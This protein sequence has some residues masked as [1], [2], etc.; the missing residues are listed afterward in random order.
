MLH[1]NIH[2]DSDQ[3]FGPF[4]APFVTTA[5]AQYPVYSTLLHGDRPQ[6]LIKGKVV[7]EENVASAHILIWPPSKVAP[8][9]TV[10]LGAM[11]MIKPV[12]DPR[13]LQTRCRMIASPARADIVTGPVDKE[14]DF[15]IAEVR[16]GFRKPGKPEDLTEM[17]VKFENIVFPRPGRFEVRI[18][19]NI[20]AFLDGEEDDDSPLQRWPPPDLWPVWPTEPFH[21]YKEAGFCAGVL[22][23]GQ[24]TEV[25]EQHRGQ[26]FNHQ[27]E[28]KKKLSKIPENC[29]Q[30]RRLWVRPNNQ[31]S[32]PKYISDIQDEFLE[33][34]NSNYGEWAE[35][36]A[37]GSWPR[38]DD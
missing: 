27:L 26:Y 13:W 9:E 24:I 6:P 10:E 35:Y 4:K 22:V 29:K 8:N 12:P 30:G 18:E 33:K 23:L 21:L 38:F 17:V 15:V 2:Y 32:Q 28:R 14:R 16:H 20:C 37:E 31:T 1:E 34:I 36:M 11:L 19:V 3:W 25:A 5:W 7:E